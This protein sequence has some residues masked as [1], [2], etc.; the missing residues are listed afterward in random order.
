M[1]GFLNI[2]KPPGMSS[3]DVV[4]YLKKRIPR[5]I[6]IGHGGTLD[7]D[8]CGVLPVCLGNAVRL[9]DYII[10]KEKTYL[11]EMTLGKTTDTQDASGQ[12]L[13]ESDAS[14]LPADAI[15]E[16]L[17]EFTGEILQT[18]PS[19]SAVKVQG[20]RLYAL[21]RAGQ[22]V[23]VESRPA[24]V[25]ALSYVA[26]TGPQS[27]LMRIRCGKGVYIRTLL[28]DIG[29]RLGCGAYMSMLVREQAGVFSI[30]SARTLSSITPENIAALLD[31]MDLPLGQY[32]RVSVSRAHTHYIRN[33][34]VLTKEKLSS[35]T[36]LQPGMIV[37]MY[38][39]DE[40]AGM[41][42]I[43][44]DG[45]ARFKAMLWKEQQP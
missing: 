5:G 31:P 15:R 17:P 26:S 2:L 9:F 21:A 11:A 42:V 18:P 39:E 41:C 40:F 30:Q 8:A 34:N 44:S 38:L 20:R 7:P 6:R 1:D 43:N 37:R 3:G 28:H 4:N 25:H 10:D 16:V 22:E 14:A 27:H 35:E 24:Q 19:Y 12:V 32:P 45:S 23:A 36:S 29:A 13:S 33:G